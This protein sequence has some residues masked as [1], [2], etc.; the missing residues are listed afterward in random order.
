M[1]KLII[2]LIAC[3]AMGALAADWVAVDMEDY[4]TTASITNNADNATSELT[5]ALVTYDTACTNTLAIYITKDGI[6][7]RVGTSSV[8]NAKYASIDLTDLDW[9]P[10][11]M[12]KITT[13]ITNVNTLVKSE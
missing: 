13:T 10:D 11:D 8:T 9:A 2:T 4:G 1:K 12:L 5:Y 7:Y 6:D 3:V